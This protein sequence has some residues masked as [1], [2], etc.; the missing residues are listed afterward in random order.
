M[1]NETQ[2]SKQKPIAYHIFLESA[3]GNRYAGTAYRHKKGSGLG[4]VIGGMRYVAFA[5][6]Q[7]EEVV[8][9]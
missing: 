3:E 7:Q 6:R 8:K 2:K 9:E 4:L 1:T 5:P